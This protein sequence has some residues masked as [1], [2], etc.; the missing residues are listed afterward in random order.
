MF[1]V[2]DRGAPSGTLVKFPSTAN[3]IIATPQLVSEIRSTV[4]LTAQLS[5]GVESAKRP[6]LRPLAIEGELAEDSGD[7][8]KRTSQYL[9]DLN[10]VKH[11]TRNKTDL[12][13]REKD[14]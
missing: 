13:Q 11:V 3:C 5:A 8:P 10:G 9:Q 1:G 12:H 14:L 4:G 7:K 2:V 6:S